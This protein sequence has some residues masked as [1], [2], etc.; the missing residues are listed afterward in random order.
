M[1]CPDILHVGFGIRRR[2]WRKPER[3]H[4]CKHVCAPVYI[5]KLIL[6]VH[7][8]AYWYV[9]EIDTCVDTPI[10]MFSSIYAHVHMYQREWRQSSGYYRT[11]H[12]LAVKAET[13]L[14]VTCCF[15]CSDEHFMY[16][17]SFNPLNPMRFKLVSLFCRWI[18]WDSLRV[19]DLPVSHSLLSDKGR[20]WS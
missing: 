7:G 12:I 4:T 8:H 19:R 1:T 9:V 5:V 17:F 2:G 18:L 10:H 13:L 3:V 14:P 16:L 15:L 11:S 20:I 6:Q